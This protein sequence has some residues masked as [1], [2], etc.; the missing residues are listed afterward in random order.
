MAEES[1]E[2][3]ITYET[4]YEVLRLE[5]YRGELQKLDESFFEKLTKYLEEKKSILLSSETK[6][7]VFASQAIEKTR[8]QIENIQKMIKELYEK[9]ESKIVQMA[10]FAS[11]MDSKVTEVSAL[12][13]DERE[14]Y[15]NIVEQ[16]NCFRAGILY[17]LMNAK[18]PKIVK[19]KS[20]KIEEMPQDGNKL[21]RFVQAVPQFMGEDMKVYGPFEA[22]D[23]A[24][25]PAAISEVLIKNN[26]VEEVK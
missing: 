19:P 17:N 10:L 3:V 18:K 5:K 20:I 21:V 26:K 23:I 22:E 2:A 12:L 11:R 9:R 6:D 1:K 8:K 24:N 14:M 15:D 25:L 4:L 13:K 16:L 7:S